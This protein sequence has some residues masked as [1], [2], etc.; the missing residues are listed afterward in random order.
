[1]G[2]VLPLESDG[3]ALQPWAC[4]AF[5][6]VPFPSAC[7]AKSS[8]VGRFSVLPLSEDRR[9][10]IFFTEWTLLFLSLCF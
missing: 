8:S 4:S 6:E 1:M 9:T 5:P 3:S 10:S 2:M 7:E